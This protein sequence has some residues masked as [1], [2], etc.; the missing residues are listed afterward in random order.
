[1]FFHAVLRVRNESR[2]IE[3]VIRSLQPLCGRIH[4]LDDH[5]DDGTPSICGTIPGV[6]VYN[7]Q[8]EGLDESRDRD[9]LLDR[10]CDSVV[11]WDIHGEGPHVVCAIDGDEILAPGGQDA[12]RRAVDAGGYVWTPRIKYLWDSDDQWRSDGVY[13]NFRRPSFFRL[14]NRQFRYQRTQWGDGANFHCSSIPQELLH[15]SIHI[16]ADL[17]HLG[18]RDREDRMRKYQWY[19]SIDPNNA[20]E[21]CYRHC[22]QGDVPEIPVSARLKHAGPLVLEA[23]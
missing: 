16:D 7:S 23:I 11:P 12:L 17:L 1:M 8:F 4:V 5:S 13:R 10:V 15:H 3:R 18:Y 19:N 22:I 21:D 14:I 6:V 20:G 2:W 9:F